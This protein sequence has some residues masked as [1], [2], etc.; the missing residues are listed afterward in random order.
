MEPD[1]NPDSANRKR[2]GHQ[3]LEIPTRKIMRD[4]VGAPDN[5]CGG[6]QA[7]EPLLVA[8]LRLGDRP[9]GAYPWSMTGRRGE[10]VFAIWH[11]VKTIDTHTHFFP[12]GG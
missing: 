6:R 1:Q 9:G 2:T 7:A 10:V 11:S 3:Q 8:Y 5:A 12:Q 4:Y